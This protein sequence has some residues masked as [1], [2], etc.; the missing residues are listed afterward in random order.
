MTSDLRTGTLMTVAAVHAAPVFLDVEATIEKAC[1]LIE[2]AG[3]EGVE[4]LVFPEVFVPG[5]PYWINCYPPLLQNP[6]HERYLRSSIQ[7]PG[8]ETDRLGV[9]AREAGV[10]IVVGVNERVGSSL[11]NSQVFIDSDGTLLGCHRKLQPTFAE[12]TIWAQGDGST[13]KVWPM[14]GGVRVGGLVCWE[15]TMNLARHAMATMGEQV[16][17]ASWP[18]LSPLR[19]WENIFDEQVSVMCRNHALTAQTFVVV[20]M[21]PVGQDVLDVMEKALGPQELLTTGG[22]WSAIIHPTMSIVGGPRTGEDEGLVV[23][24]IDLADIDALKIVVDSVGHF[25]R[26]DVLQLVINDAATASALRID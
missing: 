21:N 22:G 9:A 16:H 14:S 4:L 5:F 15:H 12:R 3:N 20:S 8:P 23:A 17:A 26:N 1:R 24:T 7:V 2:Q 6:L 25:S 18:A 10:A 13:L 19:G 11:F